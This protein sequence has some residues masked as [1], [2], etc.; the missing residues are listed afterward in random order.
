MYAEPITNV[1]RVVEELNMN[2]P[3]TNRLLK[4]MT[5]LGMLKEVTG[6]SRNRLLFL[7]KYRD[8]SLEVTKL[9]IIFQT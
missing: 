5:E 7:E 8:I 6:F 4:S 3:T 9:W 1:N 2:Y